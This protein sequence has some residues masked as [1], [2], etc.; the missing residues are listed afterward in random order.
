V[1]AHGFARVR[2]ESCKDELLVAFSCKGQGVCPSCNAKRAHVTAPSSGDGGGPTEGEPLPGRDGG[3]AEEAEDSAGGLGRA[4]AQDVRTGCV[5]L[6]AVWRQAK[7]A[8]VCDGPLWGAFDIGAPGTSH[9]GSEAGPG[10]GTTPAGVVLNLAQPLSTRP[11]CL[12]LSSS[13]GSQGWG[14]PQGVAPSRVPARRAALLAPAAAP[15]SA[16]PLQPSPS[17]WLLSR[18][19]AA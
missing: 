18:L 19:Y 3:G 17:T 14:V 1:L 10:P 16:P 5:R 15:F 12:P 9:A 13:D 6:S 8:G 7:G 2:C 11:N 4:A